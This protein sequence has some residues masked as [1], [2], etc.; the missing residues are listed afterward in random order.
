MSGVKILRAG[1]RADHVNV[2]IIQKKTPKQCPMTIFK[3][4]K[5]YFPAAVIVAIILTLL[6][7]IGFST[8]WN[9]NRARTNALKFVHQQGIATLQILEASVVSILDKP[10]FQKQSIDQLMR[11]SG[12]NQN[13][14][15]AYIAD[16]DGRIMHSSRPSQETLE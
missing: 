11:K 3:F 16:R 10:D 4:K 12:N 7:F 13:I 6:V 1:D 8:Y 14:E 15:F 5:L 2:D 9:M